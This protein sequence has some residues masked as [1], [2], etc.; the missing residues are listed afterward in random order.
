MTNLRTWAGNLTYA[1]RELL[2]PQSLDDLR[3]AVAGSTRLRA[4][5]TRHSFSAVAD[6]TGDLVSVARL[7]RRLEIDAGARTAT[8][9]AGLR[10][11]E[12]VPELD[13]AGL[14]L[15]NL[16]SLPHISVGGATATGTHGSGE[17]QPGARVVGGRGRAG[18]RERGRRPDQPGGRAVRRCG[19]RSRTPRRGHGAHARPR[20]G[21]RGAAGGPPGAARGGRA[22]H[23]DALRRRRLQRQPLHAVGGALGVPGPEQAPDADGRRADRAAAADLAEELGAR[24]AEGPW[25]MVPG[26][27]P[28]NCTEQLGVP[29]RWHARLPHFKLEFTPSSGDE[30]QSEY[31]VARSDGPAALAAV[32]EVRDVMAPV[33]Q[34][35]EIRTIAADELWL[36]PASGRRDA[37]APLHLGRGHGGG[38]AGGPRGRGRRWRRSRLVRT[39]A[40]CSPRRLRPSGRCTRDWP[41][42]THWRQ[43]FDPDGKFSNALR[44]GVPRGLGAAG[45][46]LVG[47]G[48]ELVGVGVGV[49]VGVGVGVGACSAGWRR[50]TRRLARRRRLCRV[51]RRCGV[52]VGRA[53][54]GM[55]PGVPPPAPP[56]AVLPGHAVVPDDCHCWIRHVRSPTI[57]LTATPMPRQT[58]EPMSATRRPYSALAAPRDALRRGPKLPARGA[59]LA[60]TDL[61]PCTSTWVVLHDR[62]P[63]LV[64]EG[65]SAT[66]RAP[67]EERWQL[68][69]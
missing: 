30:L 42:R 58:T 17:A 18:H 8:V 60:L 56:T 29:G 34:V 35:S 63:A 4:L 2:E 38:A 14:A 1:A 20:A 9:S 69:P 23:L 43:E 39:G 55:P 25:H 12:V 41:R 45:Y 6:T 16:G 19:D 24:P 5:G 67:A 44:R 28:E 36:S 61:S 10:Y 65:H 22:E 54:S 21:V 64:P 27:P 15:A 68:F 13:A 48:G 46:P 31:F 49:R 52:G 50:R 57:G 33:L 66:I 53:T 59:E 37:R 11:G 7:P 62:P 40:R 3:H 26:M 51:R 47:T 32:A